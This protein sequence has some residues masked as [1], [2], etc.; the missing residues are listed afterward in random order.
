MTLRGW[1]KRNTS[2]LPLRS[3]NTPRIHLDIQMDK[4]ALT[5]AESQYRCLIAWY[6]EFDRHDKGRKYRRWRP[7]VKVK[8]RYIAN[9][10]CQDKQQVITT[11][12]ANK[13]NFTYKFD[14]FCILV[15]RHGGSLLSI[16]HYTLSKR[17]IRGLPKS[18]WYREPMIWY[19]TERLTHSNFDWEHIM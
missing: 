7:D 18:T 13:H 15:Q 5:L 1:M 8:S 12:V 17:K 16:R 6:R 10:T 2:A 3:Y 9:F 19:F 14:L 4:I 11:N